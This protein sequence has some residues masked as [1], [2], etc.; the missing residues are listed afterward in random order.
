MVI[1]LPYTVCV[2]RSD[3]IVWNLKVSLC[4]TFAA[5][6][7]ASE[8]NEIT[9]SENCKT[10]SFLR[11][12]MV[13][14]KGYLAMKRK[15]SSGEHLIFMYVSGASLYGL[16]EFYLTLAELRLWQRCNGADKGWHQV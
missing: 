7:K 13:F 3:A 8:E 5:N 10:P 12:E 14:A 2:L 9:H 6:W 11:T 4:G 1:N 16:L 15:L